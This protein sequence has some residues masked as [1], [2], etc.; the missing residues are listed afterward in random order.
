MTVDG[1]E[2]PLIG[3]NEL[4]G[5]VV[6]EDYVTQENWAAFLPKGIYTLTSM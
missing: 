4:S 6:R 5:L 1:R 3:G 2:G